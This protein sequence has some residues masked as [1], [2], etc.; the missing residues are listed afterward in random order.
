VFSAAIE[1]C[2]SW[3]RTCAI[4]NVTLP[5]MCCAVVMVVKQQDK[6]GFDLIFGIGDERTDEDM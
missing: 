4:T 2:C 5:T 3:F 6:G 1:Y